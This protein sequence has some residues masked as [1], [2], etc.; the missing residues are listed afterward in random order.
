MRVA[1]CTD[2]IDII[3]RF[4]KKQEFGI[5]QEVSRN[6]LGAV[7]VRLLASRDGLVAGL[8]HCLQYTR[9]LNI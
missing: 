6:T 2:I 1:I 8:I 5:K 4:E 7:L 9:L 3:V